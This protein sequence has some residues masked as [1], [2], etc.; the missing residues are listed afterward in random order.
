M[1]ILSPRSSNNYDRLE[2]GM[3]PN[4][5]GTKKWFGWKKFALGAVVLVGMIWFFGPREPRNPLSWGT[6]DKEIGQ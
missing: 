1:A 4:R 2:N 6:K 5:A 3:G